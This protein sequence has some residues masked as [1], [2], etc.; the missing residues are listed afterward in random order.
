MG[1]RNSGRKT[2]IEFSEPVKNLIKV[3]RSFGME[4]KDIAKNLGYKSTDSLE[5]YKKKNPGFSA[6]CE[7]AFLNRRLKFAQRLENAAVPNI[8]GANTTLAI[9]FAE[10]YGIFEKETKTPTTAVQINNQGEGGIQVCFVDAPPPPQLTA[11][12]VIDAVAN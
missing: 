5:D 11:S 2:K 10:K 7:V 4:W 6:E 9:K 8:G 3:A 12:S 1:G